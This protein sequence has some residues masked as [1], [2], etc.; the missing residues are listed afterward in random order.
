MPGAAGH[1]STGE[2]AQRIQTALIAAGKDPDHLDPTDLALMEDFHSS[3]RF[4]TVALLE[5][6]SIGAQDRVLDAGAGIGGTARLL[7]SERGCRVS[8]LDITP[9]YCE[10][11]R[12]LNDACGLGEAIEVRE[13][14]VLALPFEEASFDVLISQHVQMNVAA[15][16]PMYAEARRVLRA[17]GRLAIWDVLAGPAGAP[18]FPVPWADRPEHSHLLGATELRE[19]LAAAGFEEIVW[20]DLTEPSAKLMRTIV[21][22][23]PPPLGL[24]VFVP[25]FQVR[26]E[27]LVRGLEQD[28]LRLLQAV[29]RA[30]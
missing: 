28:R 5:L 2:V 21:S 1:Y 24:H 14:D 16:A 20:N 10:V 7:A 23:P 22:A 26:A 8:A 13:G 3:G 29:L 12:R 27:N 6:A 19:I 30:V 18:E 9:E 17:G 15:K 11:A 25:G 4:A